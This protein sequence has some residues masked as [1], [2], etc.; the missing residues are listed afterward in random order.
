MSNTFQALGDR[1]FY[2]DI[3]RAV[4]LHVS[5]TK[6]TNAYCY[7]FSYRGKY[8]L[9]TKYAGVN[10]DYGEYEKTHV[11]ERSNAYNL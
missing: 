3:I 2:N 8:S 7:K 11:V 1:L 9:S 4:K 5:S 6:I 10:T